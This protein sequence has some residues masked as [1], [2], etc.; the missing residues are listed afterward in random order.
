[1]TDPNAEAH[2]FAQVRDLTIKGVVAMFLRQF[3]VMP[4]SLVAT[5]FLARL[6]QPNDFGIYAIANFW[7]YIIIG[8]RDLGFGAALIQQKNEPTRQEWNTIFT[9][10]LVVVLVTIGG[11]YFLA[12]PLTGLY[13]LD[14][15][16]VWVIRGLSLILLIGLLGSL[17][18]V[19]L[20]RQ[21][22]YDV[23]AKIDVAS[24]LLFH[25]SA[26]ILALL[27]FGV[28]SFIHAAIASEVLRAILLFWRSSWRVGFSWNGPF[29]RSALKFGSVYQLG[30][31]TSLLRDN[32]APLLVGPLFGPSAVGYLKWA[33]RTAFLTSQVFTQIVTRVSFPSFSRLQ[34]HPEG[35]GQAVEK[36]LR[37]LM[38]TTVPTLAVAAALIPWIIRYVFTNKWEP[39][40]I[41]FYLLT[42][43]MLGGNITTPFIG[44]LNAM[45]R[46]T[47]SLK[48]LSLWTIVDWS[49]AVALTLMWGFNGVAAAY[50]A[51]VA[52]P[53]IWLLREF[54]QVALIDVNYAVGRPVIA[55]VVTC[56]LIWA[57]GK[58]WIVGL[59][60]LTGVGL[61]GLA[62][63][64]L[65]MIIMER[66]R[67]VR[68]MRR[69][70]RLVKS[71]LSS[72]LGE[73]G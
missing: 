16:M 63:Y 42:L 21:L 49:L 53:V 12:E 58:V 46:V 41:A 2:V 36:M 50:A 33:E 22:A 19:M 67:F 52:F 66:E 37:Y 32:I 65:M 28:W 6:L 17:P 57:V 4:V 25:I 60:S 8:L 51:G 18:N 61:L 26:V 10:Q 31:L 15:R 34:E 47:R 20:E 11:L 59:L 13:Q 5:I 71:V 73:S 3:I 45:G 9:L 29:L 27:G 35:I 39:A 55:G 7:I 70:V 44:V 72:R 43:R 48:I 14:P 68:E 40:T 38:L 30:G 56:A 1:M 23:I 69:E 62:F 64:P 54:R 24:T